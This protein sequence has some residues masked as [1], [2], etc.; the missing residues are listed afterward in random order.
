[1]RSRSLEHRGR[2]VGPA[3]A[4]ITLC[5]VTVLLVFSAPAHALP[6]IEGWTIR[7]SFPSGDPSPPVITC[8]AAFLIDADTGEY[9]F[10]HN[11]NARLPMASTT[12]IMTAVLALETLELDAKVK[13]SQ[14]AVSTIGSKS[15]LVAG[16]VLTVEQLLHALMV[17]SGNDASI[18]LAEAVSGNVAA[19]VEKMNA[20][21]AGEVVEC[22]AALSCDRCPERTECNAAKWTAADPALKAAVA[23]R[24]VAFWREELAKPEEQREA[25]F[26]GMFGF[27]ETPKPTVRFAGMNWVPLP[28][29]EVVGNAS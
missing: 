15:R 29:P 5:L 16:E 4:A 25:E 27:A 2:R 24:T 17:V 1:M 21:A 20:K 13:V 12:K 3:W 6:E 23:E 28:R 11:A 19:F 14:N 7:A 10:S 8:T 26:W 9:L 22:D 18:A